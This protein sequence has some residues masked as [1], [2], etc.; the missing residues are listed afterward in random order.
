MIAK[1]IVIAA[2]IM[3]GRILMMRESNSDDDFSRRTQR[4]RCL[5]TTD[6]EKNQQLR[7]PRPQLNLELCGLRKLHG[8]IEKT[9]EEVIQ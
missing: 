8:Y 7:L 2:R 3:S 5:S 1:A 6:V 4:L 9:E